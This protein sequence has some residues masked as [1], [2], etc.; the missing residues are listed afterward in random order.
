MLIYT[1]QITS[2]LNYTFHL[3]FETLC[4]IKYEVTTDELRFNTHDGPKINYSNQKFDTEFLIKPIGLLH[5]EGISVQ[6][7]IISKWQELPIFYKSSEEEIPFDIF[8]ATFFLVSRYEEYLPHIKDHHGRYTAEESIA[9]K[10]QFLD[11]P[12]VNQWIKAFKN[13]LLNR[14]KTIKFPEQK[15]SFQSTID[16]DAAYYFLEKGIVRT[17]ASFIKSAIELDKEMI[18]QRKDVLLGRIPDPYDTFELQIKLNKKYNI[19]TVYFILLA[20]YGLNDKNNLI[21]SR[22]FQLLV[23]HLADNAE[24]AIHP[25]YASNSNFETLVI[26]KNRL[27]R[28]VKKEV[29]NSRQHFLKLDI[30]FTYRNLLELSIENDFSMGYASQP[31]FRA[32]ICTPYYFYDLE[33]ETSTNLKIHPFAVMDA[34]FNYYLK[35]SPEKSF[36]MIKQIIDKVKAVDGHFISL[37]HNETWSEYKKWK[38]WSKLYLQMIEYIHKC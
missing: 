36:F 28:I 19:D 14:F 31:G 26:E 29:K 37:W 35:L 17:T 20:D 11:K 10:Y 2:R 22:K 5:E 24:V 23:K 21:H 15:F 13:I 34:T 6:E 16:V 4:K 8:S 7:I 9:Y 30:P 27:E 25:S 3:I 38:G 18:Q 32:S 33:L 12:L 1:P